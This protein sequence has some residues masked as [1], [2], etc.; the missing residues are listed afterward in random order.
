MMAHLVA[1]ILRGYGGFNYELLCRTWIAVQN[2]HPH[3]TAPQ[4]ANTVID[5]IAPHPTDAR[6][7]FLD[8]LI[9]SKPFVV[10]DNYDMLDCPDPDKSN[11]SRQFLWRENLEKLSEGHSKMSI[12]QASMAASNATKTMLAKDLLGQKS[13]VRLAKLVDQ[14]MY[15]MG[16]NEM[17]FKYAVHMRAV[18]GEAAER[19]I[20]EARVTRH[21]ETIVVPEIAATPGYLATAFMDDVK[22]IG[23][24]NVVMWLHRIEEHLASRESIAQTKADDL[25]RVNT[26]VRAFIIQHELCDTESAYEVQQRLDALKRFKVKCLA[27]LKLLTVENWRTDCGFVGLYAVKAQAAAQKI[28]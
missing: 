26:E 3:F 4:V 27:D 13:D 5:Y 9:L 11:P 14:F 7:Q 20:R 28:K 22:A 6:T 15:W 25:A 16:E 24:E 21:P 12:L 23:D 2:R 10:V 17:W 19:H 1:H 8:Y 18:S